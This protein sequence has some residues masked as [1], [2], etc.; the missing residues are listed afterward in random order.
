MGCAQPALQ[1]EMIPKGVAPVSAANPFYRSVAD[2][3]GSGGEK[4]N[5]LWSSEI[6][7]GSFQSALAASLQEAGLFSERGAYTLQSSI[8][9]VGQPLFGANVTVSMRVAFRMVDTSGRVRFEKTLTST[10]TAKFSDAVLGLE[11]L[12]KANEGAAREN[13]RL[14]LGEL[15]SSVPNQKVN[16][17]SQIDRS[18]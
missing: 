7:N 2:V 13:V 16:A 6:S 4:T 18:A 12:R 5:P 17:V 10:H 8:Q 1:R 9:S 11:R 3:T 15:G 14:L